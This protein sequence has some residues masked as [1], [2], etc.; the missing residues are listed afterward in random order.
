MW[1]RFKTIKRYGNDYKLTPEEDAE[2]RNEALRGILNNYRN[3]MD[4]ETFDEFRRSV[5]L[6]LTT[7]QEAEQ[8]A[9]NR[10]E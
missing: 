2:M 9:K 1:V 3:R 8:R 10:R 7:R 5:K 6:L 4:E